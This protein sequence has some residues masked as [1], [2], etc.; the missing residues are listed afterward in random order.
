MAEASPQAG[1]IYLCNPNNPTG[2]LTPGA[3]IEWIL[4]NKPKGCVLLMDEAYIHY[5]GD[6]V[7]SDLVAKDRDLIILRS[8]SK[9]YG[10]AALRA[11]AALGRPDLLERLRGCGLGPLPAAGMAAATAS[12][13][14]KTLAPERRKI[15]GD[16]REDVV[17][18]LEGRGFRCVPSYSNKFMVDVKRPGQTVIDALQREKVYIGRIWPAWPTHVRVSIGTR[19]EMSKFKAALLKVTA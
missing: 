5:A 12:L 16:I 15:V 14:S 17:D 4:E 9:L 2:T 1:L 3:D 11:G 19:A 10:M 8:F 7:C 13:K 6:P 18:F